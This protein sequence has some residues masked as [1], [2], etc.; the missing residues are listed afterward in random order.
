MSSAPEAIGHDDVVGQPPAQL[1]RG[2]EPERLRA[3]RVVGT[4]VHV[5]ERPRQ[6]LGD[7]AA[8]T[9][10]LVVVALDRDDLRPVGLGRQDLRALQ[11]LGHEDVAR[12]ARLRGVGGGGVGEVAGGRAA[13]RLV[14]ERPRHRGRDAHDTVLE[15]VRRVDAVVLDPER[16]GHADR[17][18]QVVGPAQRREPGAEVDPLD[19][20]AA[21]QQRFVAPQ[22]RGSRFGLLAEVR[23][24][25][26]LQ[27]V[28]RLERSE[29][30]LAD[31][32][33]FHRV[34]LAADAALQRGRRGDRRMRGHHVTAP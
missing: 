3:L 15:R 18:R 1:L 34:L 23:A 16:A 11:V 28:G 29:T 24:V 27:V 9:V 13:D 17:L 30:F 14:A 10:H 22:R 31:R 19:A 5:D 26:R 7:L 25:D 8:Q 20:R 6:R 32:E 2:L 12:H 33:R 21:G 4:H